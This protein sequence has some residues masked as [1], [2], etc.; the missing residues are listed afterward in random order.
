QDVRPRSVVAGTR[1]LPGSF[2]LLKFRRFPGAPDAAS[3]QESR[4]GKPVLP[5]VE[6][7]RR[8]AAPIIRGTDRKF[9]AAGWV[10]A[11]PRKFAGRLL[12]LS[13]FRRLRLLRQFSS[14]ARPEF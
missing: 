1:R 13:L 10:G 6:R 4:R 12:S 11:H 3:V 14:L 7:F 8:G 9:S 5:Y 2:Q